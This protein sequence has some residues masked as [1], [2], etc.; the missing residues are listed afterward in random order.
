MIGEISGQAARA[1]IWQLLSFMAVISVNLAVLNLLPIPVPRWGAPSLPLDRGRARRQ[2]A[3]PQTAAALHERGHG[4]HPRAH[5]VD[6]GERPREGDPQIG[7]E[8]CAPSVRE[9]TSSATIVAGTGFVLRG[10]LEHAGVSGW[11]QPRGDAFQREIRVVALVTEVREEDAAEAGVREFA[12][13]VRR[14]AVREVSPAAP[15]ALLHPARDRRRPGAGVRRGS[16]RGTRKAQSP[17]RV[18]DGCGRTPEIGRDAGARSPVGAVHDGDGDGRGG[19]VTGRCGPD[20]EVPH[21]EPG[22]WEILARLAPPAAA[23]RRR[24]A[25]VRSWRGANPSGAPPTPIP[26]EWSR[27]SCVTTTRLIASGSTP[28][29][30]RRCAS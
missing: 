27:C 24:G 30:A 6:G 21:V 4:P 18:A 25:W 23:V 1:G 9:V 14:V 5:G 7:S 17:Q 8:S 29:A 19:V 10:G 16:P 3:Q 20:R 28:R 15:D 12:R 26:P 11:H 13:E 2:A 22:G